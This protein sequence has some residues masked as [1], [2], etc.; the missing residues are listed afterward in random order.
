MEKTATIEV[1]EK[2]R[3]E[4]FWN[5]FVLREGEKGYW[6]IGP[7]SLWITRYP[8][9]WRLGWS[10]NEHAP[11]TISSEVPYDGEI[12]QHK[13]MIKRFGFK[14]TTE[15]ITFSPA[16]VDLPIVARPEIPFY[17]P[18]HQEVTL[19]VS[20]P[21]WVRIELGQ[22]R[23]PLD[24]IPITHPKDTWVG[25]S[26]ME[27][28]LCYGVDTAARLTLDK[29]PIRFHNAITAVS[30]RN[31]GIDRLF[32]ERL[33]LPMPYFSLFEAKNKLYFTELLKLERER[34]GEMAHL[35]LTQAPLKEAGETKK[36][37]GPR[38]PQKEN[39][40]VRTM[41]SLFG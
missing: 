32:L 28:E 31:N 11:N 39:I 26:T 40:F 24:E 5:T 27:G 8:N 16:L 1:S 30:I 4:L 3:P 25:P 13:I 33:K 6:K 19:Y 20:T 17:I 15:K 38:I 10:S 41:H 12:P 23:K 21:L 7:L 14:S 37:A 36:I 2:L 18:D 29:L 34:S 9:E 35:R 22:N